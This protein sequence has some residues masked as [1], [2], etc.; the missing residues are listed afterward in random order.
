MTVWRRRER[1][2]LSFTQQAVH[3]M[4]ARGN[5]KVRELHSSARVLSEGALRPGL[6]PPNLTDP[7]TVKGAVHELV[8]EARQ[9]DL[10]ARRP[11]LVA[12]LLEDASV[13]VGATPFDGAA[14][15]GA[16]GERMARFTLRDLLPADGSELRLAWNVMETRGDFAPAVAGEPECW[17]WLVATGTTVGVVQEYESVIESLGWSAGRLQSWTIALGAADNGT[18]LQPEVAVEA[19]GSDVAST[20]QLLICGTGSTMSCLVQMQG[21]PRFHRAW[22]TPLDSPRLEVELQRLHAYITDRLEMTIG[23]TI[24]CGSVLWA[25]EVSAVCQQ[26][27][28]VTRQIEPASAMLA[29]LQS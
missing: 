24:L 18:A 10:L 8:E 12:L 19:G 15:S 22:R 4:V 25:Q 7:E 14:P 5:G 28:W 13:R 26:I 27:G 3:L 2:A 6:R 29:T 23:E 1:V 20:R 9:A 21:V 17:R 16:E 11:E